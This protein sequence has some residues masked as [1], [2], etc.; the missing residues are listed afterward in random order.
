[1]KSVHAHSLLLKCRRKL[2]PSIVHFCEIDGT[3]RLEQ[4]ALQPADFATPD[5]PATLRFLD[6]RFA[7]GFLFAPTFLF[8]AGDDRPV[9]DLLRLDLRLL[10]FPDVAFLAL[11]LLVVALAPLV[12]E[13]DDGRRLV[14]LVVLRFAGVAEDDL[15]R[16]LEAA[17]L[18]LLRPRTR[19]GDAMEA[20][21]PTPLLQGGNVEE[22]ECAACIMA[23]LAK[24]SE[25]CGS[26]VDASVIRTAAPLLLDPN[27]AVRHSIAGALRNISAI[28]H[29]ACSALVEYDVM[30]PLVTLLKEYNCD[31]QPAETKGKIDS[32][33]EIFC[34]AVHLLWNLCESSVTSVSIFNKERLWSVLLPCL[35]IAKY[36]ANIAIAVGHCLHAVSEDNPELAENIGNLN[37]LEGIFQDPSYDPAHILL[38]V[39]AS[40][41]LLNLSETQE[42]TSASPALVVSVLV[43]ALS[44]PVL[45][46]IT[47]LSHIVT[48]VK[49]FLKKKNIDTHLV[50][51]KEQDLEQCLTVVS[52][53]LTAKQIALEILSNLCCSAESEDDEVDDSDDSAEV[54]T[55]EM[56]AEDAPAVF[57][58]NISCDF[59]EILVAQNII[60][61]VTDHVNNLD[62]RISTNL[63][64]HKLAAAVPKRVH[65]VRCRALL[66][67]ANLAQSLDP[68][69]LGGPAGLVST[70]T[71]LA[72]M[73]FVKMN[74][75]DFEFLE[76]S[77][78]A[79]RSVL[80]ALATAVESGNVNG[81]ALP[82][83]S[84]EELRVLSQ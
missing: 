45:E 52:N 58:L 60:S 67:I 43:S 65:A 7:A 1:M 30:T 38:K 68:Q 22:R 84:D 55:G 66:C 51:E 79:C 72:Q 12:L 46:D 39:L 48:E 17:A 42:A 37:G 57:P 29:E 82:N 40:G 80:Q 26:L 24:N 32:K 27:C 33:S 25:S 78:S 64:E 47:R 3:Q 34:E 20:P 62:D 16:L 35:D 54:F 11:D 76:A 2:S 63:S 77:T 44:L 71:C 9:A 36:G 6:L 21:S 41:I 53:T 13:R 56:D 50:E 28:N 73:A 74:P 15:E 59:H 81:A 10:L 61:R 31:W 83:M 18:F 4:K 8:F 19:E 5:S 14:R 70:W 49:G 75:K 23:N 69:D